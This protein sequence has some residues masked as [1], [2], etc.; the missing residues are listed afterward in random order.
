M[1]LPSSPEPQHLAPQAQEILWVFFFFRKQRSASRIFRICHCLL[2]NLL[3]C[4][5]QPFHL[6]WTISAY[7]SRTG[8]QVP[9][10]PS[11]SV[12]QQLVSAWSFAEWVVEEAAQGAVHSQDWSPVW[13][14]SRYVTLASYLIV[15]NFSLPIS[16]SKWGKWKMV[17]TGNWEVP[18][19]TH[20]LLW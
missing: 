20:C 18:T 12:H 1:T 8:Y 6:A 7:F 2:W 17:S 19:G 5:T 14:F 16:F 9:R 10:D 3:F 4:C 13:P 15:L 11:R